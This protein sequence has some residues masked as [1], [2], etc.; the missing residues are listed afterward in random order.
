M[1][2]EFIEQLDSWHKSEEHQKIVDSIL[3]IP[4]SERNYDL[5]LYCQEPII[6]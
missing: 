4:E 3:D 6:I 2:S 5:I 1:S